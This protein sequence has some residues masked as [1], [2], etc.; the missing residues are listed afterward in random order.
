VI[1]VQP[2]NEE[3]SLAL[4]RARIPAP[5]SGESAEDEKELVQALNTYR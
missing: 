3:E 1:A 2:T 5:E 4:L